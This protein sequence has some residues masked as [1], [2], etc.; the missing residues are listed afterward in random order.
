MNQL[1]NG[2][3]LLIIGDQK[4]VIFTTPLPEQENANEDD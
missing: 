1:Q 3:F 2:H 4:N